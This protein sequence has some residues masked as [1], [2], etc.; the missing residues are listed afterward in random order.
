MFD[1]GY[2]LIFAAFGLL[3]VILTNKSFIVTDGRA[4]FVRVSNL[5]RWFGVVFMV[6]FSSVNE[7]RDFGAI[8]DWGP[9]E[10]EYQLQLYS[11]MFAIGLIF[12]VPAIHYRYCGG[13]DWTVRRRSISAI[14]ILSNLALV[15]V[16]VLGTVNF[17]R[18]IGYFT[19]YTEFVGKT[20]CDG[21][22]RAVFAGAEFTIVQCSRD[23][24]YL[25]LR[26][27][28]KGY[29]AP[30]AGRLIECETRWLLLMRRCSFT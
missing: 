12:L 6:I 7:V 11:S 19:T 14:A 20:P 25:A 3:F 17:R 13:G 21:P 24:R 30:D 8:P 18:D 27:S 26:K 4:N 28:E 10:A 2:G 23:R 22:A 15:I 29:F 1:L 9:S 5:F 16:G